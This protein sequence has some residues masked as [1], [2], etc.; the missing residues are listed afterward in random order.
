MDERPTPGIV[1]GPMGIGEVVDRGIT[2]ARRNYRLLAMIAAW[3]VV[4]GYAIQAILTAATLSTLSSSSSGSLSAVGSAVAGTGLGGLIAGIASA[5]ASIALVVACGKLVDPKRE[6]DVLTPGSVYS[7]ATSRLVP[8]ILLSLIYGATAIPLFIVFP[9]GVYV[10]VR[11]ANA[12][13]IVVL[14]KQGPIAALGRSWALTRSLWW[15]TAIVV[16]IAWVAVT[17]VE[18][19][20]AGVLSLAIQG[21]AVVLEAPIIAAVLNAVVQAAVNVTVTPFS[22][23][24]AVVLYYELRARTEGYDLEQ[25]MLRIAPT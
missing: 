7:A 11:W 21:M 9:L 24:I 2:L 3:A 25:R 8:L 12:Y 17:F 1:I 14:E 18:I 23:A 13:V 19:S 20:M 10:W 5:I 15:H 22:V 4:P 6:P 16:V